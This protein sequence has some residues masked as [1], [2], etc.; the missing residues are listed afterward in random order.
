MVDLD[1]HE[2]YKQISIR[3]AAC[4][5][6]ILEYFCVLIRWHVPAMRQI[7]NTG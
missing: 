5:Q 2:H 4:L 6:G 3:G 1:F 7:Q